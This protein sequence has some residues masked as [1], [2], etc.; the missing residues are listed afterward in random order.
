MKQRIIISTLLFFA[1]GFTACEKI[2]KDTPQ[3]IKKLIREKHKQRG[4]QI[5]EYE[6]NNENIYCWNQPDCFD[7]L[8]FFYD[9]N[10]N[11]LWKTGG[12]DGEGD[13]NCPKD[14]Y[15]KATIKRIIWTDKKTKKELENNKNS[16]I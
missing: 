2:E 9:K 8:I 4:G 16:R 11:L 5:I 10:A 13:G 14:F 6:Y 3:A 15:E 12:L 1:I 7:C